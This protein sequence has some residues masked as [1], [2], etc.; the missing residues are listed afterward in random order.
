MSFSSD[1]P[2]QA[3]QLPISID[4]AENEPEFKQQLG[5]LYK[6]IANSVNSKTGGLY[7]PIETNSFN[8][9]FIPT[10]TQQFRPVYRTT[11]NFGALPNNTTKSVSHGIAFTSA[12]NITNIYAE[13]TDPTNL[14]YIPIPY[15]SATA[16]NIIEL[17]ADGTNVNIT[18]NKDR[19]SFTICFVTLE[20][21]KY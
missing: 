14:I 2:M 7:L 15:A 5:I 6:R 4:F 20:Y 16:A 8:Q 17:N 18:T 9:Y 21:T 1:P 13:A 10:N 19:T 3:N 11:V 12:F